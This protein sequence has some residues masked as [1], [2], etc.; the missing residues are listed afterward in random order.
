MN[1]S[2][3]AQCPSSSVSSAPS[4][5]KGKI[6]STIESKS[7][8]SKNLRVPLGSRDNLSRRS[9]TPSP[10]LQLMMPRRSTPASRRGSRSPSPSM[11]GVN[12]KSVPHI[13]TLIDS[14]ESDSFDDRG[15]DR[16]FVIL[17]DR[18]KNREFVRHNLYKEQKWMPSWSYSFE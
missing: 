15:R 11:R 8:G 17:D 7:L 16:A 13:N 4:S 10:P 14:T 3:S 1:V 9:L 5:P 2:P 12:R 18:Y 6:K